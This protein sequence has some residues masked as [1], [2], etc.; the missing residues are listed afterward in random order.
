MIH[1]DAVSEIIHNAITELRLCHEEMVVE[2][3]RMC[4]FDKDFILEHHSDFQV[5]EIPGEIENYFYKKKRL[6]SVVQEWDVYLCTMRYRLVFPTTEE[7]MDEGRQFDFMDPS[8]IGFC[9]TERVDKRG[10]NENV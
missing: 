9:E 10:T 3:F 2:A 5:T 1:I 6:F 4:G 8:K 7:Y